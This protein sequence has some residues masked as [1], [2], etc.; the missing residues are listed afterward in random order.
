MEVESNMHKAG[1]RVPA[2][3]LPRTASSHKAGLVVSA[4]SSDGVTELSL[5]VRT[6]YGRLRNWYILAGCSACGTNWLASAMWWHVECNMI[7]SY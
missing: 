4:V 3:C 6:T 5:F 7:D 1:L 2:A